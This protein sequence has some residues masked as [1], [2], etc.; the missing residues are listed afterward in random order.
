MRHIH[1]EF[2]FEI[3]FVP[4]ILSLVCAI[5]ELTCDTQIQPT[6]RLKQGTNFCTK[7]AINAFLQYERY[8][9]YHYLQQYRPIQRRHFIEDIVLKNPRLQQPPSWIFRKL[10]RVQKLLRAWDG[11]PFGHNRHGAKSG[12]CCDPSRGRGAGSP[13]KTV[14]TGPRPTSVRYR[15]TK[16]YPDPSSHFATTNMLDLTSDWLVHKSPLNSAAGYGV[17]SYAKCSATLACCCAR[18]TSLVK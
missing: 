12:G 9:E 16:W 10:T 17:T 1:P 6:K 8:R 2:G 7:I 4:K 11:R 5:S 3:G 18:T 13:S 14:S 15:G